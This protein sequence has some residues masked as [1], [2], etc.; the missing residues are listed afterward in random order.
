M[1]FIIRREPLYGTWM[2]WPVL[3]GVCIGPCHSLDALV[4]LISQ[5]HGACSCTLEISL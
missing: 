2:A 3:G 5:Q 1:N 4:A